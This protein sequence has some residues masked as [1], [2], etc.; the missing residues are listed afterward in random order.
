MDNAPC[1]RATKCF[2]R[3]RRAA[4][5]VIIVVSFLGWM[6]F[7]RL[8]RRRNESADVKVRCGPEAVPG[9]GLGCIEQRCDEPWTILDC[10]MGIV[11]WDDI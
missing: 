11:R 9:I 4:Q 2:E 1:A 7:R 6:S 3:Y 10:S 8:F 5:R